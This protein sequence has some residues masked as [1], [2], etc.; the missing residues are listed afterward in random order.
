MTKKVSDLV[1]WDL[2]PRK[3]SSSDKRILQK[4]I[5]T[6]GDLS[7]VVLNR[8]NGMLVGGN[9]RSTVLSPSDEITLV[10]ES[11]TPNQQGTLAWGFISHNGEKFKYREVDWDETTHTAAALMANQSGGD[12]DWQK[13]TPMMSALD[14]EGG[15]EDLELTGFNATEWEDSLGRESQLPNP[16]GSVEGEDDVPEPPKVAKSKLGELWIL[17]DHRLLCGDSTDLATVERLMNGQKTDCVHSDPPYGLG[18]KM[19]GGTW[20]TKAPH[21]KDMHTWDTVADQAFFDSC[22]SHNCDTV[23]WGGNYF[24][25][26]PSRGWLIWKKPYFPTMADCEIAFTNMDMNA[27]VFEGKRS[28]H[29]KLHPTQKPIELVEWA[30]SYLKGEKVLDLF[31]GSGSTLIACEKTN[32]KCFMMELSPIYVDVILKR[33][34]D[35]TGKDPVREDGTKWSEVEESG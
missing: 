2:N 12:W 9:Q 26:P 3:I 22:L 24:S 14:A 23:I 25:T 6:F 32:R 18:K 17:G 33:W 21:Y 15:L 29:N 30:L 19:S 10:E 35:F 11:E 34:S 5:D 16:E 1:Q 8:R 31:G 28:D 27:R 7:G 13:L 4:G 20:A